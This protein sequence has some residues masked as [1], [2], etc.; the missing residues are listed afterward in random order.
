MRAD[1]ITIRLNVRKSVL[2]QPGQTRG[3]GTLGRELSRGRGKA[4]DHVPSKPSLLH[5]PL[6]TKWPGAPVIL[7]VKQGTRP[8]RQTFI[9]DRAGSTGFH[10]GKA[11]DPGS[12]VQGR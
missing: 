3:L 5:A 9:K 11:K 1:G 7:P 8:W 6:K 4:G 10:L 12:V 2:G